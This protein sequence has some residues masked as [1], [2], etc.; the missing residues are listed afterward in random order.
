VRP[1][2]MASRDDVPAARPGTHQFRR[3]E[4]LARSKRPTALHTEEMG[5]CGPLLVF[6]HGIAGSTR[7]WM[8]RVW[9]LASDHRLVAVDLLGFGRSPIP[10]ARYTVERHVEEL[11]KTIGD[12]GPL[13]LVGHSYGAIVT[14]A[15][16]A[17]HP[18]QVQGLVLVSLPFFMSESAARR[19]F[20]RRSSPDRWVFRNLMFAALACMATRRLLRRLLPKFLPNLPKEVVEDIAAHTWRS[21]TSTFWEG[22]YRYHPQVAVERLSPD[23]PVLCLHG[24]EDNTAPLEGV[25]SLRSTQPT[26]S[27][28]IMEGVDHHPLLRESAQC[29]GAI[30][31]FVQSTDDGTRQAARDTKAIALPRSVRPGA[32]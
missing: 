2:A 22:V 8:P 12:R 1:T 16:A 10:W 17:A 6:L 21:F 14:L 29:R 9:P 11:H 25:M 13:I 19:H 32:P 26:W 15:Y 7:Y 18:A 28:S 4:W 31:R 27:F 30:R 5:E 23:L 3:P 20:T 24:D